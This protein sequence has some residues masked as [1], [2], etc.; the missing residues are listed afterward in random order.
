MKNLFKFLLLVLVLS[1]G[2]SLL[3]DYQLHRGHLSFTSPT[4]QPEKYTLAESPP[5]APKE[6]ASLAS[7]SNER[8]KLVASVDQG[9]AALQGAQDRPSPCRHPARLRRR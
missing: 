6:I 9:G 8:R 2:V 3:Y 7:L 5:I 4:T 1:A